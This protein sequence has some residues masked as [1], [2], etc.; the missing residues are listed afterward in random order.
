MAKPKRLN[1]PLELAQEIWDEILAKQPWNKGKQN[2]NEYCAALALNC[3]LNATSIQQY[4]YEPI[5]RK[6]DFIPLSLE[7]ITLYC[8]YINNEA[9]KNK[10]VA[11]CNENNMKLKADITI[12]KIQEEIWIKDIPEYFVGTSWYSYEN[13][14]QSRHEG[15]IR[16]IVTIHEK[17][18][19][20]F[21][22]AKIKIYEKTYE[23]YSGIVS[24]DKS[25][26][27]LIFTFVTTETYQGHVHLLMQIGNGTKPML[28]LGNKTF[29]SITHKQIVSKSIIWEKL[30]DLN[31]SEPKFLE[32][33]SDEYKNLEQPIKTYLKENRINRLTSPK[34]VI[35][36]TED[37][38]IWLQS[39]S[40]PSILNEPR[41]I[42]GTDA[43]QQ[44][45]KIAKSLLTTTLLNEEI[46]KHTGLTIE[47]V[48]QLRN[49]TTEKIKPLLS[50]IQK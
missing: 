41:E 25:Y 24:I 16:D 26:T 17:N 7:H 36:N 6:S 42:L 22:T 33:E 8:N 15:L 29:I 50:A 27:H 2:V 32:Y 35:T 40:T 31:K 4:L 13:N 1:I 43:E 48:K 44:A 18:K 9:L 20:G 5:N 38:E 49:H 21:Y 45:I 37:L 3:G 30:E 19:E 10:I 14:Y 46:A 12:K 11:A 23:N 28:C 47:Q 34:W 39:N